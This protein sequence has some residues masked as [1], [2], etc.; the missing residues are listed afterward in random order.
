MATY[1]RRQ[2]IPF[3]HRSSAPNA[4]SGPELGVCRSREIAVEA[5]HEAQPTGGRGGRPALRLELAS[6]G[7]DV[8]A[9]N[10]EQPEMGVSQKAT[11]GRRTRTYASQV[12]PR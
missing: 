2:L 8:T 10:L 11:N 9:A 6:E 3:A 12:R 7:P 1:H 4:V 5:R